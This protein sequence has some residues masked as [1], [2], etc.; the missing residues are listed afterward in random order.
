MESTKITEELKEVI[1]T[2]Y[3]DRVGTFK[4]ES[5]NEEISRARQKAR[6]QLSKEQRLIIDLSLIHI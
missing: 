2:T 4:L 5:V 6:G 3:G 1:L